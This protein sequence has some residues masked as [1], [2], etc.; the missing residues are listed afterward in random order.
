MLD[1]SPVDAVAG[2][3]DR[4]PEEKRIIGDFDTSANTLWSLLYLE[5]AKEFDEAKIRSL[6]D[7]M[8]GVPIFVCSPLVRLYGPG[9]VDSC[10]HRLV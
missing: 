7:D 9:H 1:D 10:A 5:E 6:K 4:G 3:I 8:E 2:S